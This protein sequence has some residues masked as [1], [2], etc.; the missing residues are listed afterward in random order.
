M[1]I[2]RVDEEEEYKYTID[3]TNYYIPSCYWFHIKWVIT[4]IMQEDLIIE[5]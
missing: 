5:P 3:V 2:Y 4:H 1:G